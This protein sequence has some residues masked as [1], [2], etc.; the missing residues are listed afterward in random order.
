MDKYQKRKRKIE[1]A[2]EEWSLVLKMCYERKIYFCHQNTRRRACMERKGSDRNWHLPEVNEKNSR[3]NAEEEWTLVLKCVMKESCIL[4]LK[5]HETR[6]CK[7]RK[8]SGKIDK[9]QSFKER[10]KE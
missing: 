4:F 3:G 10:K 6:V 7:E 2:E 5:I 8:E 9:Y 1:N